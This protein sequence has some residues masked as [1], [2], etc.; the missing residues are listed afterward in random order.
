MEKKKAKTKDAIERYSALADAIVE[1]GEITDWRFSKGTSLSLRGAKTLHLLIQAAGVRITDDVEHRISYADLNKTYHLTLEQLESVI[2][3]LHRTILKLKLKHSDGRGFTQ[4][5][6]VITDAAR[7]HDTGT[8]AELTYR[9]SKTLRQAIS[10]STHWAVISRNAV[11]AFESKYALRLYSLLA[12]RTGLR[13]TSEDF[14]LDDL[15]SILGIDGD[16][17]QAFGNLNQ[18]V[19]KSSIAELNQL[20]GFT[21]GYQA[22]KSGRSVIGVR[23]FWGVKDQTGRIEA[24][25]ELERSKI[26]RKARREGKAEYIAATEQIERA[27]IAQA[28]SQ[29]GAKENLVIDDLDE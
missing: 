23:I 22:L 14:L 8:Q 12:L 9:F 17:Y 4:S 19:L 2:D 10:N 25:K 15:R 5:G 16:Q 11:L 7:D 24:A 1:A 28:L 6:V 21:V 26:G 13:K 27:Y 3:E 18:R 29:M 20:A